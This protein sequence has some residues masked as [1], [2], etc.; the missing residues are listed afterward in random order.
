MKKKCLVDPGVY[1]TSESTAKLAKIG[2][3]YRNPC[4][5]A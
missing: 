2:R 4:K 5:K 3:V 1:L